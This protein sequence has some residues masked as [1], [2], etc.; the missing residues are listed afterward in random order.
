MFDEKYR[1]V[2]RVSVP[3]WWDTFMK[4]NNLPDLFLEKLRKIVPVHLWDKTMRTFAEPKPTTFRVNT[5]KTSVHAAREGLVSSGF[6]LESVPWNREAFILRNKRQRDLEDTSLYAK[7]EIYVQNLSSMIPPLALGPKQGENILDLTAAPGSKTTQI[8]C[9]MEGKGLITAN[10][11]NEVRLSKLKANI[12]KQGASN[13]L[14]LPAGDGGLVWRDHFEAFDRVLLDAPCSAEGRFLLD[15]PYTYRFWKKDTNRKMAKDQRRLFKSAFLA[16]KPGGTLVYSTCT[17]APEENEQVLDWAFQTFPEA[18][19]MEPLSLS[20]PQSL[21]GLSA[22]EG[23]SFQPS[24]TRS[25]RVLPTTE[26]EG[27]FVARLRKLKTV[28]R[29]KFKGFQP[30]L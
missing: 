6:K 14:L 17:F 30:V 23:T 4:K 16:L 21:K 24:V 2:P 7:G 15:E 12:E 20:V 13:V 9:L 26:M 8:A 29:E 10:D 22:W 25:V 3:P 18:I 27:F 19:E 28:D 5:L 1:A 11:N